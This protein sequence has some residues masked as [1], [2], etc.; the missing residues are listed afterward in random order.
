MVRK[1]LIDEIQQRIGKQKCYNGNY[2]MFSKR[3]ISAFLDAYEDVVVDAIGRGDSVLMYG[4]M[5]IKRKIR[6]AHKAHDFKSGGVVDVPDQEFVK[7][8]PGAKFDAVINK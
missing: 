6:K 8:I 1:E 7:I 2:E 5:N 3:E 4:F